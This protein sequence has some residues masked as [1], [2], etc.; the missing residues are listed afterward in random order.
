LQFKDSKHISLPKAECTFK[1]KDLAIELRWK[2]LS[3]KTLTGLILHGNIILRTLFFKII[4]MQMPGYE[5]QLDYIKF[6]VRML[7]REAEKYQD[8]LTTLPQCFDLKDIQH[9]GLGTLPCK[10]CE[11]VP[12]VFVS[13]LKQLRFNS[14]ARTFCLPDVQFSLLAIFEHCK[15]Q[16]KNSLV[17]LFWLIAAKWFNS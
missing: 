3:S 8:K 11:S 9:S 16:I 1:E 13:C 15:W 2:E 12:A 5:R 4:K 7:T 17:Y 10:V 6:K 14:I